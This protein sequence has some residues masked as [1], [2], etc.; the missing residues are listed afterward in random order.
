MKS[1]IKL[2]SF[3]FLFFHICGPKLAYTFPYAVNE[4]SVTQT[5]IFILIENIVFA[6]L[7][8]RI[9]SRRLFVPYE[10]RANICWKH[11]WLRALRDSFL[12]KFPLIGR[13]RREKICHS[14]KLRV[15]MKANCLK[16][17]STWFRRCP[18]PEMK[19]WQITC[20]FINRRQRALRKMQIYC[21]FSRSW[22]LN[23]MNES[24]LIAP[25]RTF[26]LH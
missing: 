15:A 9:A 25:S 24:L 20:S 22:C 19:S 16:A 18:H 6:Y 4:V 5:W 7:P 21:V 14:L 3:N 26:S 10:N 2:K 1:S 23:F 17:V 11:L 12:V 13:Q 8:Q